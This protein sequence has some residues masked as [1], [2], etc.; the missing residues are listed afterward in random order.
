MNKIVK[1]YGL[2][3]D[4]TGKT[5]DFKGEIVTL[6]DNGEFTFESNT[7]KPHPKQTEPVEL[8]Y[9][10][11]I[12]VK[13]P[14][15]DT[16]PADPDKVIVEATEISNCYARR[17]SHW[18]RYFIDPQSLTILGEESEAVAEE[19]AMQVAK[20]IVSKDTLTK[21]LKVSGITDED[22]INDILCRL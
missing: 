18:V 7:Y 3:A 9:P 12:W 14:S 2:V 8:L 15:L 16:D 22:T 21:A 10:N 5:K 19:K 17:G 13:E 6:E 1:I 11:E 20:I 4:S